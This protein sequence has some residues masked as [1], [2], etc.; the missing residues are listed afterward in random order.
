MVP[1]R[2]VTYEEIAVMFGLFL[3]VAAIVYPVVA[4]ATIVQVIP[5]SSKMLAPL[6]PTAAPSTASPSYH[7]A[8]AAPTVSSGYRC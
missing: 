7:A 3:L 8:A 5:V 2:R 4:L 1:G 6:S